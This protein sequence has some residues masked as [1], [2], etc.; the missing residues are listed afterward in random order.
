M[1][2]KW[3]LFINA[4]YSRILLPRDRE[5]DYKK[6]EKNIIEIKEK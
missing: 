4:T 5:N 2:I 1:Y 3:A 6:K